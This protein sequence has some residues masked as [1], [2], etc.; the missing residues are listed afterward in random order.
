MKDRRRRNQPS[1]VKV[2]IEHVGTTPQCGE[3][4][5]P[6]ASKQ[7]QQRV[8]ILSSTEVRAEPV[9]GRRKRLWRLVK[10]KGKPW[11]VGKI[12]AKAIAAYARLRKISF[13]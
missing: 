10:D 9:S 4:P 1:I 13:G 11:G 2:Y 8:V 7:D 5:H 12:T 3:E 6:S